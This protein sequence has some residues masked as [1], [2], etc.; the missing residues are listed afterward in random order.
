[1][2]MWVTRRAGDGKVYGERHALDRQ[3]VIRMQTRWGAEYV[4]REKVLGTIEPGKFAD[5]IIVDRNPL[6]PAIPDDQLSDLKVLL[7]MVGGKV[8]FSA[9][10]FN[11]GL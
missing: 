6:D 2:E 3:T 4:M 11:S 10:G 9:P 5:L 7:T 8:V 1:M